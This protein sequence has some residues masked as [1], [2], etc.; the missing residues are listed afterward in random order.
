[1]FGR[2][3][4]KDMWDNSFYLDLSVIEKIIRPILIYLF[5]LV[6]LRLGGRRQL[7]QLNIMDFVVLL[8]VANAVQNGII[9]HDESVSGAVIGATVLFLINGFAVLLTQRSRKIRRLLIGSEIILIKDGKALERSI[10][11]ERLGADD[12]HQAITEA[13]GRSIDDV[14]LCIIEPNGHIVVRLKASS[15]VADSIAQLISRFDELEK[16][17]LAR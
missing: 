3:T 5:L 10:R 1:M 17:L 14:E 15:E 9:G 12:I 8:A 6:G 2:Y 11:R 16:R 7:S 4:L 13:G